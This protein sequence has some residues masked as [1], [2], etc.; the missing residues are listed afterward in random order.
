[1][2]DH[3]ETAFGLIF[4]GAVLGLGLVLLDAALG[5]YGAEALFRAGIAA[6][7]FWA[8]PR[9]YAGGRSFGADAFE[10][11]AQMLFMV[12]LGALPWAVIAAMFVYDLPGWTVWALMGSGA[13][14]LFGAAVVWSRL[15]T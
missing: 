13:A 7:C 5:A 15:R 1:M 9:A 11:P 8:T 3:V 4:G 12:L 6:F 2:E 10:R 14:L